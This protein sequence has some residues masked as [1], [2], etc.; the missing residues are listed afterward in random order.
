MSSHNSSVVP[1]LRALAEQ[2]HGFFT[3][4]S[5]NKL[6]AQV[7]QC[8]KIRDCLS[9][10]WSMACELEEEDKLSLEHM[11]EWE[12]SEM[13]SNLAFVLKSISKQEREM[14]GDVCTAVDKLEEMCTLLGGPMYGVR[15]KKAQ[16]AALEAEC[17]AENA[18]RDRDVTLG[19]SIED[20]VEFLD[21]FRWPT[22]D[23]EMK[24]CANDYLTY[25]KD[26][27]DPRVYEYAHE[28][29]DRMGVLLDCTPDE[30]S[31]TSK[32][33]MDLVEAVIAIEGDYAGDDVG[34]HD[35]DVLHHARSKI[36]NAIA[37]QFSQC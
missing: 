3:M 35:V 32:Q 1:Q 37:A 14:Y 21:H 7:A 15:L 24:E 9:L 22:S 5:L 6:D 4:V 36:M 20:V 8:W 26:R 19:P 33:I 2:L 28:I 17:A 25:A 16:L 13:Y 30:R 34:Y 23:L 27:V 29:H 31:V 11:E 12:R 18:Q 10:V